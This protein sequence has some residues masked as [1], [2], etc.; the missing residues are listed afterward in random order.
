[1]KFEFQDILKDNKFAIIIILL[2]L[3]YFFAVRPSEI[4]KQ[5]A[6]HKYS[7][8]TEKFSRAITPIYSSEY[9]ACLRQHGLNQ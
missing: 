7:P 5:C 2:L 3:M 4:R 6:T 8:S 1:M 9:E